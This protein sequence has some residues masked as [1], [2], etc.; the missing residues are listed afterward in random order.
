MRKT[1]G[2]LIMFAAVLVGCGGGSPYVGTWQC[3]TDDKLSLEITRFEE[4]FVVLNK[5]PDGEFKKDGTFA[6]E[7]FS[8]GHNDGGQPMELQLNGDEITCTNPPNFCHC[9]SPYKKV[10]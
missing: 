4:Y 10:N 2:C 7:M 8:V 9:D 6:N 1:F 5:D 3:P